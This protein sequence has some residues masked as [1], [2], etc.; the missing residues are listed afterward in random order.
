MFGYIFLTSVFFS[1]CGLMGNKREE[2]SSAMEGVRI[3]DTCRLSK[4][5][6][7]KQCVPLAAGSEATPELPEEACMLVCIITEAY[8]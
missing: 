3:C 5:T 4:R 7:I 2:D 8:F 1:F 6:V